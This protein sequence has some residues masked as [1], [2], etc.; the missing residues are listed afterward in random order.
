MFQNLQLYN[1]NND[2]NILND[3]VYGNRISNFNWREYLIANTDLIDGGINTKELATKHYYEQGMK[4]KR[5]IK[6]FT[7]DWTQYIAIND[8]LID[9][10]LITKE[11]AE[12]HYIENGYMEGRRI[13]LKDFDWE[14]YIY[15]NNHLIHTGINTQTKAIKHWIE[16]GKSEGL[17][18][19]IKPL[20][21]SY[22]KIISFNYKNIFDLYRNVY[23][24]TLYQSSSISDKKLREK[25]LHY[26]ENRNQ[27]KFKY[28]QLNYH[29]KEEIEKLDNFLLVIDF[30]CFGGGCSFFLN[31]IVSY[32]KEFTHFLIVRNFRNIIYFYLNDEII[33]EPSFNNETAFQFIRK[34]K[35]KISKIFFNSIVEH[36]IEFINDI[37]DLNIDSTILTHDYSLFFRKPQ[38]HY[39]DINE[40]SVHYKLNIHKFNRVITQHIGNLHTFGKYMND[41][42]NIIVS[43][44]PD[45][46]NNDQKIINTNRNKF[47]IG[48][49]G[50][51]SDVKGYYLLN[52]LHKKVRNKK[53]IEVIVLGKVHIK[54]IK[55][56]YSY[57][58]IG[59]LNSLLET[60]K[61]NVLIELSLW[62]ESFSFTLTLAMITGLP[63]IYQNKFYPCTVQRRLSLYHN[64]HKFDDIHK[65]SLK[66]IISKKQDYFFTIKPMI[67]FPP[68]WNHYFGKEKEIKKTI[69]NQHYNVIIVT[70]KIYVSQKPLSYAPN[71]SIHTKEQRYQQVQITIQTIRKNIPDSF[72]LLYD[73]SIFEDDE[74]NT[75][76]NITDC[77]INHHNDE[78]VNEFTNNSI[79]KLYGEIAQTF[80]MLHYLKNYYENMN[81]KNLFKITGR[82]LIND[83]FN[84]S[85]YEN[86]DIIFKRNEE[87]KDRAYYFTCFYKIS[88]SKLDYYYEIMKQLYEDIQDNAYEFEDY[89]VV[90]PMLLHKNFK[91][92][93]HLGVTQNIAVWED[94]SRI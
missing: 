42:N 17:I 11:K 28:L 63:I 66:W 3:H 90:L 45:Y 58:T 15:F 20:E 35:D 24:V 39:Y 86:D 72:I 47:V 13:I 92:V 61:P 77:F 85:D 38:L 21:E 55:K 25:D 26:I 84:Y 6:T 37:L 56:Q 71:R 49:I 87:V 81:I 82:Y 44:L 50:D 68:F 10:G 12:D 53:N 75:L 14:F 18:T 41:Y 16:Y 46:R 31:S 22:K 70:S 32:F 73:N 33:F 59:D 80:K 88:G 83:T 89:E 9:R 1:R 54:D 93:K 4:E 74:Y 57:H 60:H 19:T 8:D 65:V 91:T 2:K 94:E 62:P 5:K 79:H 51:I 69:L 48:I 7:F 27:P 29:L 30:P 43:A 76:R 34:N 64:A 67:Y 23:N 52:E 40:S 36:N 78:I